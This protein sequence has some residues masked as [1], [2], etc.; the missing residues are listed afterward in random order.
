MLSYQHAYHAGNFAD[1]LKHMVSVEILRYLTQKPTPLFYLDTH[2]GAGAFKLDRAESQKNKEYENG[3]GRLWS[4]QDLPHPIPSLVE[5][6]L[7]AVHAFND[8][9]RLESYP[10]SPWLAQ[11]I[12]RAQDRLSLF[13][14][15]PREYETLCRNFKQDKRV[16]ISQTNGFQACSSQLPPRE[17]RGYVLMDPPYEEKQDYRLVVDTLTRAY[18]KFSGGTYALW[19]PV[20]DR[21]RITQLEKGFIESGVRNIQLFELGLSE[22]TGSKGMTSSGMLII[23]PPWT[24]Y[25]QMETALPYLAKQLGG[26]Q[27]VYRIKQ[28]VAE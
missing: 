10:G 25:E 19:Y 16:H 7:E 28:L 3:I 9:D 27:G 14:L 4:H 8:G 6:Y 17:R 22:D 1:V 21:Y 18:R 20:V 2:S 13:E 24:L 11:H 15:H 26:K 23:N 5:N 12:L